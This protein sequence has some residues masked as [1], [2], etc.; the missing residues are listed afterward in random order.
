MVQEL[1]QRD[2][3]G[4]RP[5]LL[6]ESQRALADELEDDR[7]DERL[8]HASDQEAVLGCHGRTGRRVGNA[9]SSLPG[10]RRAVGHDHR[11]WNTCSQN[12]FEVV[13]EHLRQG[14]TGWKCEISSPSTTAC[15]TKL[16]GSVLSSIPSGVKPSRNCA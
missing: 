12:G 3:F 13:V 16:A 5:D 8:R 2:A 15:N 10:E 1:A 4:D 6:V 7:G 9:C 14:C 11:A